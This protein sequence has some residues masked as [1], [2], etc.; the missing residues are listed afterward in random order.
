MLGLKLNHVSKRGPKS[1]LEPIRINI[2]NVFFHWPRLFTRDLGQWI[3]FGPRHHLNAWAFNQ[4]RKIAGCA[5][6]GNAGTFSLPPWVNDT[7]MHDG[8]CVAHVPW[9][10][11][12]SLTSGCW[13]WGKRSRQS[14]RMRNPQLYVF[15]K[16]PFHAIHQSWF[17]PTSFLYLGRLA[18]WSHLWCT[19]PSAAIALRVAYRSSRTMTR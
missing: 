17:V 10:M 14:R 1:V 9:Y 16:R 6:A 3:E 19:G 4:I 2:W 11:P 18:R 13:W 8:T 7:D 12:G 5:C 15:G